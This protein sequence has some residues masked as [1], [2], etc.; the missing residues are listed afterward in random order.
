[1]IGN[2]VV[3][4]TD[5]E[6]QPE[7][8]HPRFDS[9]VF[10]RSELDLI[11]VSGAPDRLRWMLWA[12]KE[13][14]YKALKK[15]APHTIFSPRRFVVKLNETLRG[16]VTCEENTLP[17]QVWEEEGSVHAIA[18]TE[19][20][21]DERILSG[22]E[23]LESEQVLDGEFPG[24]AAR[25]LAIRMLAEHLGVPRE[26]LAIIKRGRIPTLLHNGESTDIDLSLS[27]HGRLVAFACEVA[28]SQ[29]R[30]NSFQSRS[31]SSEV[32]HP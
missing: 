13:A 15:I 6:A 23:T 9:R 5:P 27:H 30:S 28:S 26:E 2:D 7:G 18:T 22:T 17:I 10:A 32:F 12:A 4:L 21:L 24:E 11:R 25:A 29:S 1:M 8:L 3:D 19:D 31:E 16:N 14:A 20:A